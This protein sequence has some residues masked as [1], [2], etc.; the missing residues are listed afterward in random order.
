M[1]I[2]DEELL[3]PNEI[4]TVYSRS[5][6]DIIRDISNNYF[7]M[8][9]EIVPEKIGF[10]TQSNR[11]FSDQFTNYITERLYADIMNSSGVPISI[12]DGNYDEY[13][14]KYA[15]IEI[16]EYEVDINLFNE[17]IGGNYE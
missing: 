11:T 4:R 16:Y 14:D 1:M 8:Y 17:I 7:R 2:P 15:E 6:T 12:L 5:A 9:E 10:S 3:T 13:K